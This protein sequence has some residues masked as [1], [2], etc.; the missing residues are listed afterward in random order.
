VKGI[1]ETK[2]MQLAEK[3]FTTMKHIKY[4]TIN[5]LNLIACTWTNKFT[6]TSLHQLQQQVKDAAPSNIPNNIVLVHRKA[7]NPYQSCYSETW[8]SEIKKCR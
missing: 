8:E 6:L 1:G 2:Q 3:G 7:E 5:Q 4:A